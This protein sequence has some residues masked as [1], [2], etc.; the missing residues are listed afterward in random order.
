[1]IWR[2]SG[3]NRSMSLFWTRAR[4]DEFGD[5]VRIPLTEELKARSASSLVADIVQTPGNPNPVVTIKT[6]QATKSFQIDHSPENVAASDVQMRALIA[7]KLD[8]I[9]V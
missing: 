9:G 6:K 8:S 7:R 4:L 5:R 3:G 1:M 2:Q